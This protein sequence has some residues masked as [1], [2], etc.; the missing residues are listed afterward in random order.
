MSETRPAEEPSRKAQ[1]YGEGDAT[2]LACGGE[3]GIRRLVESFYRV[4]DT[5]PEAERI[6]R[7]HPSDLRLSIDKLVTFL[8]GWTNGPKRYAERYGPIRI[9]QAH[10]HLDI[11]EDERDAW[12]VC[13]E[14]ALEEQSYPEELKHYLRKELFVPA[15]RIR[16]TVAAR[17]EESGAALRVTKP[18]SRTADAGKKDAEREG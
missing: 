12:L 17:K 8:C 7:M 3:E 18:D 14:R 16:Q 9:P 13:M 5:A 4:M 10:R 1:A 2:F 11:A 15:E 6:R